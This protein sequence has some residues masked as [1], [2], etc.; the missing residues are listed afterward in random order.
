[1][2]VVVASTNPVKQRAVLLAFRE[3]FGPDI[4][5][6]GVAVEPGV[7]CQP[8]SDEETFLGAQNRAREARKAAPQASFWAGIEGGV[9]DTNRGMEAFGWAVVLSA[10]GEGAA[11][12]NSFFLPPAAALA[13]RAG[14]ELGPVMDELF[15]Q[16]NTKQKG[17]AIG[18][19]T[20]GIF[21]RQNLY[22]QAVLLALI[23][24]LNPRLYGLPG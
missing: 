7:S 2:L 24:F 1:M 10:N 3:A 5:V 13:I 16:H 9:A 4:E 22:E 8:L 21:D 19:L 14:G 15:N 11:R 23:P 18:L 17:G 20:H 12:S 6:R